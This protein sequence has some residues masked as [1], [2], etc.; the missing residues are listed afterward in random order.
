MSLRS[1]PSLTFFF[2]FFLYHQHWTWKITLSADVPP[3]IFFFENISWCL[4]YLLLMSKGELTFYPTK[5]GSFLCWNCT[6]S[7]KI[8]SAGSWIIQ[9][10]KRRKFITVLKMRN[11]HRRCIIFYFYRKDYQIESITFE[12]EIF[13]NLNPSVTNELNHPRPCY[14]SC[15]QI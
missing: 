12:M 4:F 11:L 14:G 13:S 7:Q 15:E 1:T 6:M 9:T 10:V 2:P 5:C 8:L 3:W